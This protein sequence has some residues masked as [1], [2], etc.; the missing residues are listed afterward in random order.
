[1][2]HEGEYDL[3]GFAVG[4]VEQARIIDGRSIAPATWSRLASRP[5]SN[6]FSLSAA[7]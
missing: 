6:G 5:H 7:S 2:Y 1:M 4:V 3:A